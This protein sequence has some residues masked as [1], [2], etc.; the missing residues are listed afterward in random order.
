MILRK[1]KSNPI[2]IPTNSSNVSAT[3]KGREIEVK[4]RFICT[5]WKFS[6]EKINAIIKTIE[7]I[8]VIIIFI[9]CLVNAL[10]I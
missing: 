3:A 9:I 8:R 2:A 6:S 10:S 4:P 5:K 1:E 7:N